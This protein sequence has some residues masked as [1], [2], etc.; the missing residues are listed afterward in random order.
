MIIMEIQSILIPNNGLVFDNAW[1]F[2]G[3]SP[4]SVMWKAEGVVVK[5]NV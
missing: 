1:I 2:N 3:T 4:G 5:I